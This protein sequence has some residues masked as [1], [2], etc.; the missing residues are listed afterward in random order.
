MNLL[1]WSM[2]LFCL[3]VS[4]VL[5]TALAVLTPRGTPSL[6]QITGPSALPTPGSP[7]TVQLVTK[8][9]ESTPNLPLTG[10]ATELPPTNLTILVGVA[11]G[12]GIQ[13]YTCATANSVPVAL[14]AL[15]TL[16][17]ATALAY[18]NENLLHILPGLIVY[19]PLPS[20]GVLAMAGS[21]LNILGHHYFD[22]A[23]TPTFNLSSVNKIGF[24]GK[25]ASINAP[26]LA[27]KG[28]AGTGAVPWLQLNKKI[29]YT[30]IGISQVYRV[31]TAGG[32]PKL[33]C[34]VAGVMSIPYGAEYWFYN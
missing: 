25:T 19:L 9:V 28:P 23:G 21:Y 20:S 7:L 2:S 34:T 29:G 14:G 3:I 15:A 6:P 11:I 30:S 8:P 22:S 27:H 31:E 13:N 10:G 4:F 5:S 18:S 17:D 26:A 12:R 33:A 24:V 32:N 16:F 1:L